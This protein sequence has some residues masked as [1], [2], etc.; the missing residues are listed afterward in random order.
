[1]AVKEMNRIPFELI[2]DLT[3]PT[4]F[5]PNGRSSMFLHSDPLIP[6]QLYLQ[7]TCMICNNP[8]TKYLSPK[9]IKDE[10]DITDKTL[11]HQ[12]CQMEIVKNPICSEECL[13]LSK[14]Q[15]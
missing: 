13:I 9:I 12:I 10:Y 6:D 8:I 15:K 7:I 2:R 1:M 3:R 4:V 11:Y 14:L 5:T